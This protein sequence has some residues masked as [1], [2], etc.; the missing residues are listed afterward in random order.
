MSEVRRIYVEKKPAYASAARELLEN[1]R[2]YLGIP[3]VS[4]VRILERYD[5]EG[6]SDEVFDKAAGT[7]FSEPPVE[8]HALFQ[9]Y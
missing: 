4:D 6:I 1:I 2:G 9:S 3:E 7:I 5:I 8:S